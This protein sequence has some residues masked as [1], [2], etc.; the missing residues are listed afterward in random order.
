MLSWKRHI[1]SCCSGVRTT[2]AE[3]P[4]GD[5][6]RSLT[7]VRPAGSGRSQTAAPVRPPAPPLRRL[8][9]GAAAGA[10]DWGP[11]STAAGIGADAG[12]VGTAGR[13]GPAHV[14]RRAGAPT[15]AL[16][17][18]PPP[19]P[20]RRGDPV[21]RGGDRKET[22]ADPELPELPPDA[23]ANVARPRSPGAR[24]GGAG[25]PPTPPPPPPPRA[26]A[27]AA[28]PRCCGGGNARA[29]WRR[30][31]R[32]RRG[33]RS[34]RR[35]RRCRRPRCGRRRCR[36]RRRYRRDAG[37]GGGHARGGHQRCPC[38]RGLHRCRARGGGG[39]ADGGHHQ[40]GQGARAAAAPVGS[41]RAGAGHVWGLPIAADGGD[42]V[43]AWVGWV[44]E[45]AAAAAGAG[46]A[47]GAAA[48]AAA[49]AAGMAAAAAGG[50]PIAGPPAAVLAAA[51]RPSASTA[52][53]TSKT[54]QPASRG[55]WRRAPPP[56]PP[57]P[58]TARTSRMIRAVAGVT[59]AGNSTS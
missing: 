50:T 40:G 9:T 48:A 2:G 59:A 26:A 37:G 49:A 33:C 25:D 55:W 43:G 32:R 5:R 21:G 10:P 53:P 1:F 45:V 34:G 8:P 51:A 3:G 28:L 7:L 12:G 36:R 54:W 18:L 31:G 16:H 29:W 56:P 52:E 4:L 15:G 11:G 23:F 57:R 17:A 20:R 24:G 6:Y 42:G 44:V 22:P 46:A 19:C 41:A 58:P 30:P 39:G 13:A 14:H 27:A 38:G 35:D 47:G